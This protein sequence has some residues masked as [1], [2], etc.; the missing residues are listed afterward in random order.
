MTDSS[1]KLPT[2]TAF[3][4]FRR[5]G[6]F[7][8]AAHGNGNGN[9]AGA[10]PGSPPAD[11]AIARPARSAS[12]PGHPANAVRSRETR[13]SCRGAFGAVPIAWRGGPCFER[14][15]RCR[16]RAAGIAPAS[17]VEPT[18]AAGLRHRG[19]GRG[20]RF[21]LQPFDRRRLAESDR[22]RRRW[23]PHV[24]PNAFARRQIGGP[25][26]GKMRDGGGRTR[27]RT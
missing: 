11:A 8:V 1:D 26:H 17:L 25:D 15:G 20:S 3:A 21:S 16:W 9:G 27:A 13:L 10:A 22:D 7:P 4:Q 5:T 18:S 12:A 23:F 2:R 19:A 6:R 24:A 14:A